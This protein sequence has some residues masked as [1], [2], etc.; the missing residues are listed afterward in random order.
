MDPKT[1]FPI[2]LVIAIIYFRFGPGS[3]LLKKKS[4]HYMVPP[5]C[6]EDKNWLPI[7]FEDYHKQI[8]IQQSLPKKETNYVESLIDEDFAVESYEVALIDNWLVIDLE[9]INFE[10]YHH[11]V[12]KCDST[13]D[14]PVYGL[15]SNPENS[16]KDY[17][18]KVDHKADYGHLIGTFR[19][20][21]NFGVYLPKSGQNPK[22]NIS[23]SPVREIYF[24]TEFANLPN[25]VG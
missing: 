4:H 6:E 10:D 17:I 21:E 12:A 1:I 14:S 8:Y 2:L 11:L 24:D 3:R 23:R 20:N 7:D 18:I 15:C 9:K 13:T 22:G 19:N 16:R 5:A 25:M